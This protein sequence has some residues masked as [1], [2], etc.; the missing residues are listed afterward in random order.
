[1]TTNNITNNNN[2]PLTTTSTTTEPPASPDY[3]ADARSK[4]DTVRQMAA[5]FALPDG[6]NLTTAERRMAATPRDFVEKATN[7]TE[8]VPAVGA[9]ANTHVD[10]MRDGDAYVRAY[11][12]LADELLAAHR[13]VKK[14][15]T[16]RKA[17]LARGSRSI[18]KIAKN[19]VASD[20]GDDAKARVDDLKKSLHRR[21]KAQNAEPA[22][23]AAGTPNHQ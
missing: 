9:A 22:P 6:R 5:D 23:P 12:A 16:L 4:I 7:F 1:M 14:A 11:D 20:G 19:Y 17:K 18:Y 15:V 3:A 2:N 13:A 10:L 21:R 8:A